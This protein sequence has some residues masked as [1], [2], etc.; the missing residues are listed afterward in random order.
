MV[1]ELTCPWDSNVDRSHIYKEG[2]YAPLVAD[3]SQN[4][5]VS[6]Y[7]VEVT[8]RGQVTKDNRKRIR[9]FVFSCCNAPGK[10]A[11]RVVDNGSFLDF[12]S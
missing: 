9:A 6:H 2:K 5:S 8:V 3:L 10:L 7:S 1:F 4:F 12:F 11:K